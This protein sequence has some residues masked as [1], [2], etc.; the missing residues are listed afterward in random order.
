MRPALV[1]EDFG[2]GGE[3]GRVGRGSASASVRKSN[4][5]ALLDSDGPTEGESC[6]IP[7]ARRH[8]SIVVPLIRVRRRARAA[9]DWS[10]SGI[11]TQLA[12]SL[13]E[14][15]PAERGALR[16]TRRYTRDGRPR[17]TGPGGQHEPTPSPQGCRVPPEPPAGQPGTAGDIRL[18]QRAVR[19]RVLNNMTHTSAAAGVGCVSNPEVHEA[20]KREPPDRPARPRRARAGR[21]P[22]SSGRTRHRAAASPPWCSFTCC[23]RRRTSA[24]RLAALG[25]PASRRRTRPA[26]RVLA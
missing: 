20:F 7:V 16:G 10:H 26:R 1:F 13:R 9:A 4:P 12:G 2:V 15:A 14:S 8:L 22:S 11:G 25:G 19:L 21:V 18:P 17:S 5:A 6:R 23:V 24:L 3:Q